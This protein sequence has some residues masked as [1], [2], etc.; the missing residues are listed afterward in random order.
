MHYFSRLGSKAE[1]L[2]HPQLNLNRFVQEITRIQKEI[3]RNDE[4]V[5]KGRNPVTRKIDYWINT[6]EVLKSYGSKR[7][8]CLLV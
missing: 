6:K 7:P 4:R 8:G 5:V 3:E 1:E 2:S